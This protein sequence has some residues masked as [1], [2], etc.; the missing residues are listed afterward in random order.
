MEIADFLGSLSRYYAQQYNNY[1]IKLI[2]RHIQK[3]M[4]QRKID[5]ARV[6]HYITMTFSHVYKC[7]PG[8]AEIE[9]AIKTIDKDR[10][11]T[12]PHLMYGTDS[13]QLLLSSEPEEQTEEERAEVEELLKSLRNISNEKSMDSNNGIGAEDV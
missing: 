9:N 13:E 2:T 11:S 5:L 4:E 8:I 10:Y 7:N 3:R 6:L 12:P 1:Q